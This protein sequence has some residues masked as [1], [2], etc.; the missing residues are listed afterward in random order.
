VVRTNLSIKRRLLFLLVTFTVLVVALTGRVGWIQF[1]EGKEL[2]KEA[3]IQQNRGR[4]IRAKRGTILDANGK[5][6][7]MS[8][9]VQMVTISPK[10]VRGSKKAGTVAKGL[11]GILGIK[12]EDVWKKIQKSTGYEYIKR[13]IDKK[14]GD[15][16]I[17]W[18]VKEGITGVYVDED[19]RRVYPKRNLASHV[20]GFTNIDNEGLYGVERMMEQF[21]KGVPGK[22]MSEVDVGGRDIP[23]GQEKRI[24]PID[25]YNVVLTIDEN[26]QYIV[27]KHLEQAVYDNKVIRGATVIVMDPRNGEI[28]AMVSKP[29]YD[30][31]NPFACPAGVPGIDPKV[32]ADI[33]P[34]TWKGTTTKEVNKLSSTVWRNKAINDTYM[35]GSTFKAVTSAAG[36]EEGVITPNSPVNDFTVTVDGWSI[37]CWKPNAHGNQT[38]AEGVYHSCNP[39]F[40]RVAQDLGIDRFYKYL[41]AFGMFEKTDLGLNGEMNSIFQ[42]QAGGFKEIDMATASFGQ[43]FNITPVQLIR[44]Y[45]A[46]ANGGKLMKPMLVKEVRDSNGNIIKRFEPE[47]IRTVIS[48]KTSD[49]LREI[50]EGVVSKGTGKNAYVK[51]YRVAGKTGTSTTNE[52]KSE[53]RYIASFSSFAP[54]DNPRICVL[55]VLDHPDP[56]SH[57]GGVIAAPVAGRIIEDVLSYLSV[58]RRYT[59]EEQKSLLSEV[60]V[61]NVKGK[62]LENAKKLLRERGLEYRIEGD[63]NSQ[64][65]VIMEQTP[66]QD[67]KIL[68]KSVV[69]LYMNKPAEEATV[70]VPDLKDKT[71]LEAMQ[72]LN[73]VGLNLKVD[74]SGTA[75][76]QN[77]SPGETIPKGSTVRV[78]F[79]EMMALPQ[80]VD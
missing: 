44:A 48:K 17:K 27:D 80:D 57:M 5:T 34:K 22:V 1:V 41:S 14:T 11:A 30:P 35:P 58:P 77:I 19:T 63:G 73:K 18:K 53:R 38:F 7:A 40:V 23:F 2:Q 78:E 50:L 8:E 28:L 25:G 71:V 75:V 3:Y 55:V 6:L 62:T 39:V 65:A 45:G 76:S 68:Q 21:L 49:T 66:K 26:I 36:L 12:E 51:G 61:P 20:I 79:R 59:E 74:G 13:K 67:A 52:T 47:V 37:N 15:E 10:V 56:A 60:Y 33:D 24:E 54:A 31:N 46:I 70:A 32:W 64:D 72:T 43:Q 4:E 29:D 16:I 9:S 69:I 42:K